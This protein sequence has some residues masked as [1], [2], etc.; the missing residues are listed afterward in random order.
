MKWEEV[1]IMI[2]IMLITAVAIWGG[3]VHMQTQHGRPCTQARESNGKMYL[4]P[5]GCVLDLRGGTALP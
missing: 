5:E 3:I 1:A 2:L 4:E